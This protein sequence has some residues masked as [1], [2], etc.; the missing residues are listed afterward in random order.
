[1]PATIVIGMQWGDEGKGKVVDNLSDT[2]DYN[3]RYNGGANAGHTVVAGGHTYKLNLLPSGI[4]RGKTC[5]IGNGVVIDPEI[6]TGE[7]DKVGGLSENLYIS[8]RAHLV[9]P[10]NRAIEAALEG[11][12]KGAGIGTTKRGI[13]PTYAA[14]MLRSGFRVGDLVDRKGN[15]DRDTFW[16][17]LEEDP[18][19]RILES[20]YGVT[21]SREEI[22]EKYV[23]FA[24]RFR[25][26]VRDTGR[27][28]YCALENK[29]NVLFEGAQ[30]TLLDIDHGTYPY[31]TSSNATVGGAIT[32][33]GVGFKPDVVI[34]VIKAYTTRVGEGPFPTELTDDLGE[35]MRKKGNEYGTTTGRARRCGW[36]DFVIAKYAK[37]ANGIT[38]LAVTKLD[39]LS[40]LPELKVCSQYDMDGKPTSR[41][42]SRISDLGD[43]VPLLDAVDVWTEDLSDMRHPD[44]LPENARRYIKRMEEQLQLPATMIS[45]GPDRDQTIYA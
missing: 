24:E 10:Q 22:L 30:G 26:K 1:M 25:D 34:G 45:V 17:K 41:F 32:G 15:V 8:D 6:L 44:E 5:I 37:A 12:K 36:L 38:N 20:T 33:S 31:V 13:G 2:H 7:M 3:V 16:R 28:I 11:E 39:I 19:F 27:M 43:C 29:K 21:L 18:F 14:K 4:V 42:P 35:Q 40:A 23:A 9:M